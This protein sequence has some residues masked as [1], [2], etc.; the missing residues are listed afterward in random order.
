MAYHADFGSWAE[1]LCADTITTIQPPS[2][3]AKLKVRDF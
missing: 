2:T 3:S 1:A